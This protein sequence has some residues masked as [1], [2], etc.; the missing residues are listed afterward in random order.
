MFKVEV[1][2]FNETAVAKQRVIQARNPEDSLIRLI[3][4][5][6]GKPHGKCISACSGS[7]L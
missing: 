5:F 1:S 4:E 3:C 2:Y 6:R 7:K